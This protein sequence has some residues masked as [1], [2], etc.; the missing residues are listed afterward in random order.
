MY[1]WNGQRWKNAIYQVNVRDSETNEYWIEVVAEDSW[2]AGE[3]AM[4]AVICSHK[5]SIKEP[6]SLTVTGTDRLGYSND[7]QKT[8]KDWTHE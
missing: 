2:D 8:V 1:E 4:A 5:Y 6:N 7:D 3:L